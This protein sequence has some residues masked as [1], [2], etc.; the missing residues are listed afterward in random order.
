MK[1]PKG[2]SAEFLKL[3]H[4]MQAEVYEAQR[5]D[6]GTWTCIEVTCPCGCSETIAVN[7]NLDLKGHEAAR[8]SVVSVGFKPGIEYMSTGRRSRGEGGC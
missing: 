1:V 5:N 2:V 7:N 8:W 3:D 4:K 6:K